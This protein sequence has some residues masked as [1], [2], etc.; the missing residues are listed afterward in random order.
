MARKHFPEYR[1]HPIATLF[2]L[3]EIRTANA[4]KK[5]IA[6]RHISSSS[7]RFAV[8]SL[9]RAGL[10]KRDRGFGLVVTRQGLELLRDLERVLAV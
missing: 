6:S 8:A 3:R 9:E 5:H 7:R 2:A 4:K 10:L 1:K